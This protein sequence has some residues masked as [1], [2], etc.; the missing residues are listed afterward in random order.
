MTIFLLGSNYGKEFE[1]CHIKIQSNKKKHN[2][3][4]I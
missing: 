3:N 4:I 1:P 2:E